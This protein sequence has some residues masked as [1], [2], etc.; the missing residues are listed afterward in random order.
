MKEGQTGQAGDLSFDIALWVPWWI[1]EQIWSDAAGTYIVQGVGDLCE[2]D[3]TVIECFPLLSK[4]EVVQKVA[5]DPEFKADWHKVRA[6]VVA[7]SK[8]ALAK[9]MFVE[10]LSYTGYEMSRKMAFAHEGEYNQKVG[11]QL[12]SPGCTAERITLFGYGRNKVPA[13]GALL[14]F[15]E[16]PPNV[17]FEKVKVFSGSNRG[18]RTELLNPANT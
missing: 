18:I 12:G 17:L 2:V 13:P 9:Q 11:I 15:A 16:L 3:G 4:D 5:E 10:S 1:T 7:A 6:G 14:E 8:K